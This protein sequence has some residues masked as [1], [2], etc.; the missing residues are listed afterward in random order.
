[1]RGQIHCPATLLAKELTFSTE[2]EVGWASE[3][4]WAL[5]RRDKYLVSVRNRPLFLVLPEL[6]LVI[7]KEIR[8]LNVK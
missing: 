5:W 7:L 1:V 8:C 4:V 3:P 2:E 6:N